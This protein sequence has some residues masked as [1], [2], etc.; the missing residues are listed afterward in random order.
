LPTKNGITLR[1]AD[2]SL[3]AL[4][5]FLDMKSAPKNVKVRMNLSLSG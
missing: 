4:H 2:G 5:V 3:A 1:V